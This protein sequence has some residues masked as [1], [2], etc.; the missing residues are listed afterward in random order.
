[1]ARGGKAVAVGNGA[2]DAHHCRMLLKPPRKN[3][4]PS[5]ARAKKRPGPWEASG[6][7]GWQRRATSKVG[8]GVESRDVPGARAATR[9]TLK[10]K[11]N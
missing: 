5:S 9:M 1:M 10:S 6:A 11:L 4:H 2:G 8:R 3:K 7:R